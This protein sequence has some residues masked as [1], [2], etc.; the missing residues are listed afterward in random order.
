[1]MSRMLLDFSCIRLPTSQRAGQQTR[2]QGE[3]IN[4]VI[5]PMSLCTAQQTS[6]V[7]GEK[8]QGSA[9]NIEKVESTPEKLGRLPIEWLIGPYIPVQEPLQ[10]RAWTDLP[11]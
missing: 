4:V 10:R 1:M 8:D 6:Q 2:E 7:P 3:E 5:F 9:P 11:A